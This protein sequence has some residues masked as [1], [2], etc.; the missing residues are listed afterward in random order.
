MYLHWVGS[1]E[2]EGETTNGSKEAAYLATTSASGLASIDNKLPDN[3]EVGNAGNG[4]PSPLLRSTLGAESSEE[5]GQDHDDISDDGN[6]DAATVHAS[7]E[8]KIQ[9]E[10][11]GSQSP[12]N[13]TSP[14]NLA[15]HLVGGVWDVRVGLADIG[16][17]V[18]D[19][20]TASHGEVGEG[21]EE[22]D[23]GGDDVEKTLGLERRQLRG[24]LSE[25][26]Q[27]HIPL[28]RS[29]P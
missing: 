5:T 15:V 25:D 8:G 3:N 12:V 6:E 9:E 1:P 14:V 19:T 11:W 18:A 27:S 16:L 2:D 13:V 26:E 23:H 29:M 7:Q 22:G 24:F 20:V 28:G 10:E 21:S 4:V 17:V